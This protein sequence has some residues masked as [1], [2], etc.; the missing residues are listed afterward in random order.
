VEGAGPSCCT[1]GLNINEENE[2]AGQYLDSANISHG[3]L[4]FRDGTVERFSITGA[5]D[6]DTSSTDG[7][8]RKGDIAG[9]YFDD[10]NVE[11]G[12]LRF[13]DGRVDLFDVDGAGTGPNQGTN[14]SGISDWLEIQETT[15]TRTM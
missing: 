11:H 1:F 10:G 4:R 15:S 12:L 8:N 9:A 2:I 5:A 14:T 3:Y 7:L 13:R 6:T